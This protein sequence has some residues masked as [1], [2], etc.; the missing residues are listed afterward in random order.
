MRQHV[1]SFIY[2]PLFS[3]GDFSTSRKRHASVTRASR[4]ES[5]RNIGFPERN[6][7]SGSA[8]PFVHPV[9]MRSGAARELL[10]NVVVGAIVHATV[11]QWRYIASRDRHASVTPCDA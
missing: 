8:A 4:V 11:T 9:E 3:S 6:A 1:L 5:R 10:D 2:S 7:V